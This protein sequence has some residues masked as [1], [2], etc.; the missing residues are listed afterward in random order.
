MSVP[1]GSC[2]KIFYATFILLFSIMSIL[3]EPFLNG[4]SVINNL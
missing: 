2:Y 4:L 3:R 1:E